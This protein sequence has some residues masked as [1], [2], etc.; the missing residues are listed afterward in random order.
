MDKSNSDILNDLD[1]LA[2]ELFKVKKMNFE[3]DKINTQLQ[4]RL[5]QQ[6]EIYDDLNKQDLSKTVNL[7]AISSTKS[8]IVVNQMQDYEISEAW[9]MV[10]R[11]GSHNWILMN[12]NKE[13]MDELNAYKAFF[14]SKYDTLE[15]ESSSSY[16][17]L[18]SLRQETDIL[19]HKIQKLQLENEYLTTS[20]KE[21]SDSERR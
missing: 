5:R 15:R 7:H 19:T 10:D 13:L 20:L 12:T 14:S 11:I 9:S 17:M 21:H 4:K 6:S 16:Q 1:D 8:G 18:L 3:L 2:Q